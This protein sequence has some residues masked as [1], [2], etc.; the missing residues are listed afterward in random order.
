MYVFYQNPRG[1]LTILLVEK[2]NLNVYLMAT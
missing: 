2:K 1:D